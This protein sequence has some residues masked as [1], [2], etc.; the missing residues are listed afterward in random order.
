MYSRVYVEITNICNMNCSFCHGHSR[1]KRRMT[2]EEFS[3][4]LDNLTE[5]TKYIYYHLMGEP[6]THPDLPLFI[7][8]ANARGYHSVVTTNGTLLPRCGDALIDAGIYKVS[9]SLHS[10]EEG[11]DADLINYLKGIAAFAD[12]ASKAGVI[13]VLRLW[14]RGYDGGKNQEILDF[15]H[16]HLVGEWAKNTRGIRV[17]DKLHIEW[18]ERFSWPDKDAPETGD[19]VFCYG[20]SD[21]FGILVDGTVVPC[22]MDSDGV[23]ALGNAFE[24]PIADILSSPRARAMT[25][26]FAR[27]R[28]TEELCRHCGY[29]TRFL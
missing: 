18:G 3:H 29:A 22:C 19:D 6:L 26:G 5:K 14:N 2:E 10:F 1:E 17:R 21:H 23:I 4:L 13:V 11:S 15:L 28:A 12:N 27:R 20:L 9:V 16:R 8:K 7:R 24:A 25:D